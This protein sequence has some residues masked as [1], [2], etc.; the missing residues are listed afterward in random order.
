MVSKAKP[1]SAEQ[2]VGALTKK[3][4]DETDYHVSWCRRPESFHR[5]PFSVVVALVPLVQQMAK[6]SRPLIDEASK[7]TG[8]SSKS[9]PEGKRGLA[10]ASLRHQK[11]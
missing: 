10:L 9:K 11:S 6:K 3:S 5:G 2:F 7:Y 8:A 1:I 4:W